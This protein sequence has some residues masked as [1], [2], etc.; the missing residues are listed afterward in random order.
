MHSKSKYTQL[1]STK[2]LGFFSCGISKADFLKKKRPI[3][4]LVKKNQNGQMSFMESHFD[5]RLNPIVVEDAK[6]VVSLLLNYYPEQNKM[7]ILIRFLNMLMA[8]TII[9]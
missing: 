6:S 2:R 1:K 8:R 4:E 5:K 7:M 9:T 3:R